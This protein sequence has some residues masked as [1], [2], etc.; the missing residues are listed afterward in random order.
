[1]P[2][3]STLLTAWL[4]LA[5]TACVTPGEVLTDIETGA[6]PGA[7]VAGVPFVHQ[8]PDTC[9]A[10]ALA[11][12]L[13]HSGHEVSEVELAETLRAQQNQGVLTI[14]LVLE[15]RRRGSLAAQRYQTMPEDLMRSIDAGVAPIVLHGNLANEALGRYHY[16]VLTAYDRDRRVWIAH[17]GEEADVVLPFDRFDSEHART[18]RW[19]MWVVPPEA[20]PSGLTAD[21]HLEL[22]LQ[23]EERGLIDA[24]AHHYGRAT[25]RPTS[26]QALINL[27]NVALRQGDLPQAQ[28]LL[29]QALQLNPESP[30]AQNSLAW[31][32]VQRGGDLDKAELLARRAALTPH[33]RPHA[34]DTLGAILQAQGRLDEAAEVQQQLLDE[35]QADE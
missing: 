6:V 17:N 20:R 34:L 1:M 5:L 7:R 27:S 12:L 33:V 11:S 28:R 30:A 21:V 8:R 29:E 19:A 16:S 31:V 10:A 22:G 26:H 14:E 15:A 3:R 23:A 32:L 24:A 35:A 2:T 18:D 25:W 4:L 9:G 13:Q